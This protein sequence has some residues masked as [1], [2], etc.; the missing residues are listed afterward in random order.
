MAIDPT[1]PA[2]DSTPTAPPAEFN[3]ITVYTN[4]W[5]TVCGV[6]SLLMLIMQASSEPCTGFKVAG[7]DQS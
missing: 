4:K 7:R 2:S 3:E 1:T 6:T 5:Q